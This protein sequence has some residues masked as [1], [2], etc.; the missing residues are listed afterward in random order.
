M[1]RQ[2]T[3]HRIIQQETARIIG[4][5]PDSEVEHDWPTLWHGR[6][7]IAILNLTIIDPPVW[8]LYSY[9]PVPDDNGL[10]PITSYQYTYD[11]HILS[12]ASTEAT[13]TEMADGTSAARLQKLRDS[14][15]VQP[16]PGHY[17]HLATLLQQAPAM[18]VS[19]GEVIVG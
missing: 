19:P 9:A 11:G 8:R 12:A 2:T 3:F 13:R 15:N 4:S 17:V 7:G 14:G 16:L 18:G 6:A 5:T 1:P 10:H